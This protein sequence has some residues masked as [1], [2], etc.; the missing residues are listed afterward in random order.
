MKRVCLLC[1][2]SLCPSYLA[3]N[4]SAHI[5]ATFLSLCLKQPINWCKHGY[6]PN[7]ALQCHTNFS[8]GQFCAVFM[9]TYD[10]TLAMWYNRFQRFQPAVNLCEM[11]RNRSW[12][13][14]WLYDYRKLLETALTR[15]Q[16]KIMTAEYLCL[17]E[18][19]LNGWESNTPELSLFHITPLEGS[20]WKVY[21]IS[22]I[23]G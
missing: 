17:H 21:S 19:I 12:F 6:T 14:C 18:E 10:L 8:R 3:T 4:A 23:L 13:N 9:F 22:K 16:C 11:F 15:C 1:R 20:Q 5:R 2:R 7:T